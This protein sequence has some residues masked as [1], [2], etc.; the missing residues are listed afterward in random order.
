MKKFYSILFVFLASL[1]LVGC[2]KA[3]KTGMYKEGTY[4]GA[5]TY[6]SYGETYV[7]TAVIYVD[8]SGMIQSC[9]IDS[10]YTKDG[11]NTTK[12]TLGDDYGMKA[13]SEN[14]GVIEGG[15][16]WYEQVEQIEKKVVEEQNLDWVKW[17]DD[18]KTK[19]DVDT[20]S[21]VTISANT[22]IEAVSKAMEKAK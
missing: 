20:I 22:Y 4:E 12:K 6:E 18:E 19:L 21:G 11:V 16:E 15:A 7:T 5:V 3:T 9:Y 1:C 17:S 13:T 14:N 10:T 8:K 2:E